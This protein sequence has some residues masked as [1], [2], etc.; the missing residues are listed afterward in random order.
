MASIHAP[1]IAYPACESG[2]LCFGSYLR[3]KIYEYIIFKNTTTVALP[4]LPR[5]LSHTWSLCVPGSIFKLSF[6]QE[7]Q[8]KLF[9]SQLSPFFVLRAGGT[10]GKAHPPLGRV[11]L[12]IHSHNIWVIST[13]PE[14]LLPWSAVFLQ[15]P[16]HLYKPFPPFTWNL[17]LHFFTLLPHRNCRWPC[18]ILRSCRQECPYF[19]ASPP[20]APPHLSSYLCI[21]SLKTNLSTCTQVLNTLG[22]FKHFPLTITLPIY[23]NIDIFIK[24]FPFKYP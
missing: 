10:P 6:H 21:P 17:L 3:V 7:F 13:A 9:H 5:N 20:P 22:L 24:Y 4:L 2:G 16:Q 12:Q 11:V 1:L 19:P 14:L 15:S 8:A 23:F 18:L